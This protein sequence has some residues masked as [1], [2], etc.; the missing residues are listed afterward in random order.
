MLGQP[1]SPNGQPLSQADSSNASAVA[2]SPDGRILATGGSVNTSDQSTVQLWSISN[3]K[4]PQSL[5]RYITSSLNIRSLEFSPDGHTLVSN[6]LARSFTNTVQLLNVSDATHPQLLGSPAAGNEFASATISRGDVMA[7]ANKNGGIQL[8]DAASPVHPQPL[9]QPIA[10][11]SG[12]FIYLATFSPDGQTLVTADSAGTI[13][14]WDVV[15]PVQ[16]QPLSQP[17][18]S[19]SNGGIDS[20]AFSPDG[21]TLV[22]GDNDGIVQLWNIPPAVL[23]GSPGGIINSMAFSADGHVLASVD[24]NGSARLWNVANPA[25]YKPLSQ[26]PTARNQRI[27][28]LIYS[29]DGR[30]IAGLHIGGP[31]SGSVQ[32]WN[33]ADP[34]NPKPLGHPLTNQDQSGFISIAFAPNGRTFAIGGSGAIQLWEIG[35]LGRLRPGPKIWTGDDVGP[36]IAAMAFSPDGR[37][38]ASVD[39]DGTI[40]LWNAMHPSAAQNPIGSAST[41]TVPSGIRT[42]M[43][44]YSPNGRV[45]TLLTERGTVELWNAANPAK[46]YRLRQLPAITAGSETSIALSS[47]GILATDN[48]DGTIQLWTAT[49]PANPQPFGQPMAGDSF[50]TSVKF[51]PDGIMAG[52][53]S[54]GTIFLWDLRV[55]DAIRR[56]CVTA[57]GNLTPQNWHHYIPLLPYQAPCHQKNRPLETSNKKSYAR[58]LILGILSALGRSALQS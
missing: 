40:Q 9:G 16:P 27:N 5:G 30:T 55:D 44:E 20:L 38:L 7:A 14:M 56:I 8:W 41:E 49:N 36:S 28:S 17:F 58:Q 34:A 35:N 22:T 57:R 51:S 12:S 29:P 10:I 50:I 24:S 31:G 47:Q 11:S 43:L 39:Y 19:K 33:V 32:L 46:P 21:R 45:L 18:S 25:A 54:A 2:F 23:A 6:E 13:Q 53:T 42:P 52:G 26:L 4:R 3:L 15:N 37:I 1:L 48:E